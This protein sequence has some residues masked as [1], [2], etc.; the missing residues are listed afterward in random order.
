MHNAFLR[1]VLLLFSTSARRR[2][3]LP[4]SDLEVPNDFLVTDEETTEKI[5][6]APG[7]N[8]VHELHNAGQMP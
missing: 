5:F 6:G 7:R 3:H 2:R 8:R 1:T 4:S